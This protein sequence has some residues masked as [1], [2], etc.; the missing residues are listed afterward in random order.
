MISLLGGW[1]LLGKEQGT[2]NNPGSDSPRDILQ[3]NTVQ[4]NLYSELVQSKKHS[5]LLVLMQVTKLTPL[6]GTTA[7]PLTLFAP[8]NTAFE[9]MNPETFKS[10][11]EPENQTK[12]ADLLKYHIVPGSYQSKDFVPG[13]KLKTIQ[14][15][16]LTLTQQD[17]SWWVNGMSR[18]QSADEISTSNGIIH[19]IE[20]VITSEEH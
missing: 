1:F 19:N 6:L 15:E 17:G 2:M 14:G 4:E 12:L 5:V 8:D 11:R 9:K 3:K 7:G 16:V 10:L 13:M 18:I 20:S